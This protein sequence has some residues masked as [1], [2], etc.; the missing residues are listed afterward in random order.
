M[1]RFTVAAA[2]YRI[3]SLADWAAYEAKL[4]RWVEQA[5]AGGAAAGTGVAGAATGTVPSAAS[6]RSSDGGSWNQLCRHLAQRTVRPSGP[7]AL[8]G[9]TYR[10]AQAGHWMI[11]LAA[12]PSQGGVQQQAVEH[13]CCGGPWLFS[14]SNSRYSPPP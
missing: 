7:I 2:Q 12:D 10:V 5:A 8:S 1:S 9:T 14:T 11:M 4:T 6:A 13:V 3:E